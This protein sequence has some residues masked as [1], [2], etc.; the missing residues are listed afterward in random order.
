METK[1]DHVRVRWYQAANILRKEKPEIEDELAEIIRKSEE[2]DEKILLQFN[3][4]FQPILDGMLE[5][6]AKLGIKYD[7]FTN[8]SK[9]IIDGSVNKIVKNL[10]K[11][12]FME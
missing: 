7:S 9:F 10:E 8:E 6:L 1:R 3:N 4:A 11:S 12:I 2:G 5:T